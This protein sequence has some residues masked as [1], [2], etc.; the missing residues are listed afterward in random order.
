MLVAWG[1]LSTPL[2]AQGE[3]RRGSNA[4]GFG[5]AAT[6]G[7]G[8]QIE[9]AEV[10]YVKRRASGMFRALSFGARVGT[11]ID[12]G[13]ILGGNRGIVFAPTL[14]VRTSSATIAEFGDELNPTAIGFDVTVE[15][16]G[17]LTSR[18]PLPI[19]SR[20][21]AIAVLP[22]VRSG[23]GEGLGFGLMV[24]PTWFVGSD[25]KTSLR[26]LFAFRLEAPLARRERAP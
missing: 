9:G 7:T 13:A 10:A 16:S 2:H 24:G 21:G 20:W 11:F 15:L 19:G 17:Y 3:P 25:G 18:S 14:G 6:L 8:W 4:I 1:A 5:F 12:E 23:G 26:G 22:G